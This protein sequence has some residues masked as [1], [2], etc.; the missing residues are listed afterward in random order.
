MKNIYWWI[1]SYL[2]LAL[3][4]LLGIYF[5]ISINGLIPTHFDLTGKPTTYS[6]PTLL[7]WMMIPL[8]HLSILVLFTIIYYYRW[9]LI[10]KYPYLINIPAFMMMNGRV[11]KS[12]KKYYV[13]KIYSIL[14]FIGI[15]IG[16]LMV[17]IETAMGYPFIIEYYGTIFTLGMIVFTIIPIIGIIWYYRRIYTEYKEEYPVDA[18]TDR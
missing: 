6:K 13:D 17:F 3:D 18:N 4:F 12:K 10:S 8:I 2:I 9:T 14:S 11:D 16:V 5:N 1:I 15:Y 7:Y